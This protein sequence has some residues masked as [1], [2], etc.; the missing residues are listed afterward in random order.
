MDID[1]LK[2]VLCHKFPDAEVYECTAQHV[3]CIEC[4]DKLNVRLCKCSE[5]FEKK[6][7]NPIQRLVKDSKTPCPYKSSGCTWTFGP[8]DMRQHLEE[9]KFRPVNCIGKK[10]EVITCSWSGRHCDTED[11]LLKFHADLGKPFNY[12]QVS[13][14]PFSASVPR[15]S[16]RLVD[17]FAK[18]FLFYFSSNVETKMIYFMIIYFG[19]RAEAQ[20]YYYE[21]QIRNLSGQGVPQVKYVQQCVADCE[22]LNGKLEDESCIALSFKSVRHYLQNDTIPIRFIIRKFEKE[23]DSGPANQRR[24]SESSSSG[25][26]PSK[27]KPTPFV[28]SEKGKQQ[29]NV[30]RSRPVG[31]AASGGDGG[32]RNSP[33]PSDDPPLRRALPPLARSISAAKG[34]PP[35]SSSPVQKTPELSSINRMGVSGVDS[36][37]VHQEPCPF[38]S[39]SINRLDAPPSYSV[40][41]SYESR[42]SYSEYCI[43][44]N[45]KP[46]PVE[47][48]TTATLCH[49]YTQPYKMADERLYLQ[50]YPEDCLG[51][52]VYRR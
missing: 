48:K 20:Q 35:S 45:N 28:F 2:C 39:P 18:H 3:G 13:E 7:E 1:K 16:I 17:A 43:T 26:K 47:C 51:K 38:M 11:H 37:I 4:V 21:F 33:K 30:S 49:R 9:C 34:G 46:P 15:T 10:L 29:Q 24:N 14:I 23:A 52:P 50:R 42:Y 12:Y 6:C 36:P 41:G 44:S 22:D 40:V 32:N 25:G 27:P 19:R 5:Y 8:N 31:G